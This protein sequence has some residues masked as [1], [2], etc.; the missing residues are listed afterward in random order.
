MCIVVVYLPRSQTPEAMDREPPVMAVR[1]G[2]ISSLTV[3]MALTFSFFRSLHGESQLGDWSLAAGAGKAVLRQH[4][5]DTAPMA[6]VRS[7][8]CRPTDGA[9]HLGVQSTAGLSP[10]I[11]R[12]DAAAA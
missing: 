11:G 8:H 5:T 6:A 9:L 12:S 3:A 4:E 2:P 10:I 1:C 7:F